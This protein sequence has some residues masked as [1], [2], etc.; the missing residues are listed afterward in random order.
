L[1]R[2]VRGVGL[3]DDGRQWHRGGDATDAQRPV[4]GERAAETELE[5]ELGERAGLLLAAV[6]GV[7]DAAAHR[8]CAQLLEDAVDRP[9][10]VQQHRQVELAGEPQL[11][12]EDPG[13]TLPVEAGDEV[14][15]ADLA[16]RHQPRVVAVRL[17]PGTQRRQV[18]IAGSAGAHRMDAE[19][20]G[21]AVA[22]RQLADPVE[23]AGI[24]RRN[25]DRRHP[26]GARRGDDGVPIGVE[27][28]RVEV[29]MRVDPHAGNDASTRRHDRSGA[30]CYR[31]GD[32][33]PAS[34]VGRTV[35]GSQP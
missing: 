12:R 30:A 3:H 31:S 7:S 19:G 11:R 14:V 6:E 33:R 21:E 1:R 13:L 10:D 34:C 32:T 15:Q 27:I 20:V 16:D 28:G 2:D 22:M 26:R 29:A 4:E 24:D 5:A 23:V 25:D 17:E 9:A 8:P 35:A 18:G